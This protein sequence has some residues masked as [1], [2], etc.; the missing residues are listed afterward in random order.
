MTRATAS[1]SIE[2]PAQ[3]LLREALAREDASLDQV[4]PI[5]THLLTIS[6]RSLFNDQVLSQV[7]GMAEDVARQLVAAQAQAVRSDDAGGAL[8]I[9]QTQLAERLLSERQ[10]T[11]FAHMLAIE[12][13][14]LTRLERRCGI[15][16][17]LPP[18]VESLLASDDA[19]LAS[20]A[21][22]LL[23]AQARFQQQVKRMQ[24]PVGELPAEVLHHC[25]ASWRAIG[26]AQSNQAID[27][28]ETLLRNDFSEGEGRL[29]LLERMVLEMGDAAT[30]ALRVGHAGGSLFLTAL[31]RQSDQPRKKVAAATNVDQ[32][33]RLVL[34]LVVAG[35]PAARVEEQLVS[36]HPD[37]VPG[38][39]LLQISRGQ[40]RDLLMG[41]PGVL[42]DHGFSA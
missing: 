9:K 17:V 4:G 40:A 38:S 15:D 1:R 30:A 14:F 41:E 12:G 27:R 32:Y 5:L 29:A 23:S 33:A 20:L 24:L 36:I 22:R 42:A 7:R 28:A 18:L 10:F 2:T 37:L 26:G 19:E 31:A 25:F 3:S 6:D 13:Q 16:P 8:D 21:M 39:D 11:G 35:L 34:A